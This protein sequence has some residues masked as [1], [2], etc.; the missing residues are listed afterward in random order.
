MNKAKAIAKV[1]AVY[2]KAPVSRWP[3]VHDA[4]PCNRKAWQKHVKQLA[5]QR[6]AKEAQPDIAPVKLVK[7][8]KPKAR[9]QA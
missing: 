7:T 6:A 3:N 8:R 2:A 4:T 9:R 1:N 5:K